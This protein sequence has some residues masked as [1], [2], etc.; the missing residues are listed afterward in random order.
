M[1]RWLWLGLCAVL[2]LLLAVGGLLVP[3]HLRAVDAGVIG[4]AGRKSPSLTA[5]GLTLLEKQQLGPAQMLWQAAQSEAVPDQGRLGLAVTNFALA[6]PRLRLWGGPAASL[7]R[8][9]PKETPPDPMVSMPF[10]E[11]LVRIENRETVLDYLRTS[12]DPVVQALLQAR[13]LTNTILFPPAASA[14]GQALDTALAE[15]GL[16]VQ[17]QL[18]DPPLRQALGELA[19]YAKAGGNSQQFEQALLDMVALGQRFNWVQLAAFVGSIENTE[20]LRRLAHLTRQAGGHVPVLFAAVQVSRKPAAVADYLMEFSQSGLQ[21][22]GASLRHGAGGL[23]EVLQRQERVYQAG[24]YGTLATW[25]ALRSFYSFVLDYCWLVPW[26]GLAVKWVLY[27]AGGFFLA[28]AFHFARPVATALEQP[29]QVPSSSVAREILFALGFLLV[30]LLLSEPFL[31]QESQKVDFPFRLRL[32]KVGAAVSP[33]ITRTNAPPSLMNQVSP[34]SLLTL[35][36][37]FVLQALIYVACLVKLAEI[38]RQNILPRMKLKLLENEDHL[39]DAGLYLGFVGTILSLIMV[40]L[41]VIKPSLMA[42]YSSTSF[43]IIF[44]SILKIFHVRPL[45][46]KLILE[47]EAMPT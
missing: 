4:L 9:F 35:L 31:A 36:L 6:H 37:F 1:K 18:L 20:T 41:G 26:A 23:R 19:R 22:L 38:R 46:R 12:S 32:P 13:S 17:E 39:F 24:W 21:D 29:L 28:L 30:I 44:V 2:G 11:F 3:A 47:S 5:A 10:V 43:G 34:L 15:T 40:S 27:L 7:E 33:G 25:P 16:L 42:A 14:A 8:L 45:R